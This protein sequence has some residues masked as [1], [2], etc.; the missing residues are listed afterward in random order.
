MAANRYFKF[1]NNW[2]EIVKI[3]RE[4][5][6][7]AKKVKW[8]RHLDDI[9]WNQEKEA[10]GLVDGECEQFFGGSYIPVEN[11]NE[12]TK[13]LLRTIAVPRTSEPKDY[14][15]KPRHERW[16]ISSIVW[17][18][19]EEIASRY[20]VKIEIEQSSLH[21]RGTWLTI[22]MKAEYGKY[23]R[24]E[25]LEI[26]DK[27]CKDFGFDTRKELSF[28]FGYDLPWPEGQ[29]QREEEDAQT[30]SFFDSMDD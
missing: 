27:F 16:F 20:G 6:M 22:K 11:M 21:Y 25:Q 4:N 5:D 1:E 12:K 30:D 8:S 18:V 13:D 9:D 2:K 24:A 23:Q 10:N 29:K 19:K 28:I 7:L 26:M 14:P 3:I 17:D 15:Y